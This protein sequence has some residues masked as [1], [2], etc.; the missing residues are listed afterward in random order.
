VA[1]KLG[2]LLVKA[3]VI[4]EGQLKAAL[5]E[6]QKWG[7]KLGEI[8]VRMD[9]CTEDLV[10]KALSKQLAIPRIELEAVQPPPDSVLK[11]IPIEMSRDMGVVPLQLKDD[12]KTLVVALADPHNIDIVDTLRAKTGC[13]IVAM[14]AG[15]TSLAK[16][17]G[18]FY[19]GEEEIDSAEA[20]F[21]LTDSQGR[22]LVKD[23]NAI[24]KGRPGAKPPERA[25]APVPNLAAPRPPPLRPPV[26]SGSHN[27]G[28]LLGAIE[29]V[30]RKEVSALKAMVELLIEKGV[31]TREEYLARVKR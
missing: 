25:P 7:G 29:A 3:N 2:D 9:F 11:K 21:K 1:I 23:L 24:K 26:E 19:Y 31:F 4:T 17:R 10:V 20:G 30:Q 22:T 8:L 12:G 14:I 5:A 13:R 18:R 6:Q 28:E 16:A 27:P 15:G